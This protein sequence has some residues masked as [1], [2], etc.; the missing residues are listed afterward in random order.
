MTP[1]ELE[2]AELAA[3]LELPRTPDVST[4]VAERI[5]R[6]RRPRRRVLVLAFAAVLV[7][8]ASLLAVSPSARSALLDWL[9]IRGVTIERV[10]ELP[11]VPLRAAPSFGKRVSLELARERVDF[12]VR[13][14]RLDGLPRRTVYLSLD[15]PFAWSMLSDD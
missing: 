2:L 5:R 1:I 13:L 9:G 14:P 4:V 10:P 8:V 15:P 3:H 7:A 12:E 6:R 11:E